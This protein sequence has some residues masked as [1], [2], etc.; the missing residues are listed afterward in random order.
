MAECERKGG[1]P[2]APGRP[3]PPPC[4]PAGPQLRRQETGAQLVHLRPLRPQ[5]RQDGNNRPLQTRPDRFSAPGER[6]PGG[7][8]RGGAGPRVGD[9]RPVGSPRFLGPR[10]CR[11]T[12][13]PAVPS[14]VW[15]RVPPNLTRDPGTPGP[16]RPAAPYLVA[17]AEWGGRV[18]G[19]RRGPPSPWSPRPPGPKPAPSSFCLQAD[20]TWQR[21]CPVAP[22]GAFRTQASSS[23]GP[24]FSQAPGALPPTS[25]T[26]QTH[27][28]EL[29]NP[30]PCL[31]PSLLQTQESG[32][33]P[34]AGPGLGSLLY[35]H[36]GPK[37]QPLSGAMVGARTGR[38]VTA[39][40]SPVPLGQR[41]LR[42]RPLPAFLIPQ[43]FASRI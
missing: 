25:L 41:G 5:P 6:R 37:C 30:L 31:R 17:V 12:P 8:G 2:G 29:P 36:R 14:P 35:L 1:T 33:P 34:L 43:K 24:L 10:G 27:D 18:L 23:S 40:S 42:R 15:F 22:G 39:Q 26:P 9:P 38:E 7:W 19:L 11:R 13:T 32:S 21:K 16:R 20:L 4:S 28:S 3:P